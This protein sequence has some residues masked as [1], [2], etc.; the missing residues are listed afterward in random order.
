MSSDKDFTRRMLQTVTTVVGAGL[1]VALLWAA[2]DALMIVYVSA[3]I[4]MGMSPP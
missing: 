2:R 4:A 3:L 1:L